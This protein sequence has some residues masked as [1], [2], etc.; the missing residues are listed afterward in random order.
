VEAID[1]AKAAGVPI[2][3]A[4]NKIDLPGANVELVKQDLTRHNLV[5][6]DFGGT[7]PLVPI[8][9]KKGQNIDKLLEILLLQA[10][11][12][13]LKAGPERR[14]RGVVREAKVE[15]GRGVVPTVLVQQ[16]TLRVGHPFV[17][18]QAYGKVRALLNER[19][20]AVRDAG[21]SAPVEVLGWDSLPQA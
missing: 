17:A 11:L 2:V 5:V 8:S 20:Q 16:G 10:D 12:L 4:A 15:Q 18:G 14:A 21:P 7:V 19:G 6:E 3:V 1:H 9:A 13:E